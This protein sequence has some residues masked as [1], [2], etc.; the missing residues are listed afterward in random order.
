M[1]NNIAYLKTVYNQGDY[2]VPRVHVTNLTRPLSREPAGYAGVVAIIGAFPSE[3]Q[4]VLAFTSYE[5]ILQHYGIEENTSA[6]AAFDGLRAAKQ[7]LRSQNH[8]A[9]R[10]ASSVIV[11]NITSFNRSSEKLDDDKTYAQILD[12]IIAE[13]QDATYEDLFRELSE[14][15]IAAVEDDP[16]TDENEEAPEQVV[17][18]YQTTMTGKKLTQALNRLYTEQFDFIFPASLFASVEFTVEVEDDSEAGNSTGEIEVQGQEAYKAIQNFLN[19]E[20]RLQRPAQFVAPLQTRNYVPPRR[21]EDAT[22]REKAN[23]NQNI[24]IADVRSYYEV[25]HEDVFSLG[26]FYTQRIKI[27]YNGEATNLDLL[28]TAAYMQG[29]IASLPVGASLTYNKTI[30]GV[31][32][33]IDEMSVG[34]NDTGYLLAQLGFPVIV[35]KKRNAL[36]NTSEYCVLNSSLPCGFDISQIRAVSYLIKQYD[37]QQFLGLP[38]SAATRA[39]IGAELATTNANV[40]SDVDIIDSI[41]TSNIYVPERNGRLCPQE[42]YI[43]CHV[44]VHGVIIVINLGVNMEESIGVQE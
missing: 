37:L 25:F 30:P 21:V 19:D 11:A 6:E 23:I 17:N 39:Q 13:N 15:H 16:T 27:Q 28:E 43:E 24:N 1:P 22:L 18:F 4:E 42:V 3:E 40:M 10:G 33:V 14:Y 26:G 38:N 2:T 41:D 34:P 29:F 7:I 44:I 5:A 8:A 36:M 9:T 32:G 35:C 12:E 20:F 31:V